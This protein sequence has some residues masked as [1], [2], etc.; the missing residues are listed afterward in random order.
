MN[1]DTLKDKLRNQEVG[2]VGS[3]VY[4]Y[5]IPPTQVDKILATLGSSESIGQ[6]WNGCD[7]DWSQKIN[8]E[9]NEFIVWGSAYEGSLVFHKK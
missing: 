2:S 7:L 6:D 3:W 1:I 4:P 5:N 9:G 8:F